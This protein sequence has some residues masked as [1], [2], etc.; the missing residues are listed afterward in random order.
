MKTILFIGILLFTTIVK[1]QT[2]YYTETKTFRENGF[3]YQADVD[4]V[5]DRLLRSGTLRS[6]DIDMNDKTGKVILSNKNNRYRF[7]PLTFRDGTPVDWDTWEVTW[8]GHPLSI[9]N[10]VRVIINSILSASERERMGK[11]RLEVTVFFN[12]DTGRAMETHFAFDTDNPFATL[13]VSV[14]RKIELEILRQITI[15]PTPYGRRLSFIGWASNID[16]N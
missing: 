12:S 7:L 6:T 2:N 13:S 16:L 14:Y 1:A 5:V 9:G 4:R 10:N 3:T 11:H 15:T 8:E